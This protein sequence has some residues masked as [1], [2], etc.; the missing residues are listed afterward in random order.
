MA[1]ESSPG[2]DLRHRRSFRHWTQVPIR[3]NDLDTL[4]HVNNTA[5]GVFLEQARCQLL[6]PLIGDHRKSEIDLVVARIVIEYLREVT[7]PGVIEV[8]TV[9]TAIGNKSFQLAHGLFKAGSD[10]CVSTG[11]GVLVW[12]NLIR[13]ATMVPPDDLRAS[14]A[15]YRVAPLL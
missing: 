11:E 5:T 15:Q 13:R 14:L 6:Y 4:G 7:Y 9:V 1:V 10:D 8:G 2:L 3:Y 12:Y